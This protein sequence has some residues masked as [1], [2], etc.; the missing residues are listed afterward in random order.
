MSYLVPC[1]DDPYNSK[2]ISAEPVLYRGDHVDAESSDV[3]NGTDYQACMELYAQISPQK[4]SLTRNVSH[5]RQGNFKV[6]NIAIKTTTKKKCALYTKQRI[7]KGYE[8]QNGAIFVGNN[9]KL[10]FR[11]KL[12]S[13]SL[14]SCSLK[15]ISNDCTVLTF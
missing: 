10:T 12:S 8:Y 15:S 1:E 5:Q 6:I 3:T 13:A 4:D 9:L 7:M 14:T 11:R 2:S